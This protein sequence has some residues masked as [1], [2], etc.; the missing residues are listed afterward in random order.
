M[1]RGSEVAPHP[2]LTKSPL[3]LSVPPGGW[4]NQQV[5]TRP[6]LQLKGLN[7]RIT[8]PIAKR[9]YQTELFVLRLL[10]VVAAMLHRRFRGCLL[11][12][13]SP[14]FLSLQQSLT[15]NNSSDWR[16]CRILFVNEYPPDENISKR[17][18]FPVYVDVGQDFL[19]RWKVFSFIIISFYL[20]KKVPA[21]GEGTLQ[22]YRNFAALKYVIRQVKSS[23]KGS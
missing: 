3:T 21:Q 10:N 9:I 13:W 2:H 17:H 1:S 7:Y 15:Y 23:K 11:F 4:K 12:I 5:Q 19:F 18:Q 6:M 14:H 8:K 20:P 22:R 16:F